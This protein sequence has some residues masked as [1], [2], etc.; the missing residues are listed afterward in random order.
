MKYKCLPLTRELFNE[1][2]VKDLIWKG[3]KLQYKSVAVFP[4]NDEKPLVVTEAVCL[5]K[6][7]T[8]RLQH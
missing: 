8:F 6:S 5:C 4:P 2:R 7:K 3:Y 1:L